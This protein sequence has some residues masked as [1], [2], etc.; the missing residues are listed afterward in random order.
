MSPY[1]SGNDQ[2]AEAAL[3]AVGGL[4]NANTFRAATLQGTADF[5]RAMCL[6]RLDRPD[7]ARALFAATRAEMK[8]LAD[9]TDHDDLVLWLACLEAQALL[10]STLPPAA[11][12]PTSILPALAGGALRKSG[13]PATAEG[14]TLPL[15]RTFWGLT[16]E[17]L[18]DG[19]PARLLL[20]TGSATSGLSPELAGELGLEPQ[21]HPRGVSP[22]CATNAGDGEWF[23]SGDDEDT[24]YFIPFRLPPGTQRQR[25]VNQA[26][27][28]RSPGKTRELAE[29]D[30]EI[31]NKA[32]A[33][34]PVLLPLNLMAALGR[35]SDGI[36]VSELEN[37]A[38]RFKESFKNQWK[39]DD[40]PE[41]S[42]RSPGT[43]GDAPLLRPGSESHHHCLNGTL[44]S[45]LG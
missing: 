7:E 31:R 44:W 24:R 2:V 9:N 29:E 45:G 34:I 32:L 6:F 42:A 40:R 8:P 28:R 5:Y 38:A 17:V 43:A 23:H 4:M 36:G 33:Y 19:K 3:G 16:V 1:R 30:R 26:Y 39:T 35:S 41:R 21:A 18:I 12:D 37:G 15:E 11:E 27:S 20:N 22:N 14:V 13:L 25:L 10:D